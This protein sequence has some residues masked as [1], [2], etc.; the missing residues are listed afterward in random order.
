MQFH[1]EKVDNSKNLLLNNFEIKIGIPN[2]LFN[3]NYI[4][5]WTL[6]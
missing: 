1:V 2:K 5:I 3:M 6:L 4:P